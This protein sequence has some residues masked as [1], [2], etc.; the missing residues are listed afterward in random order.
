MTA[1]GLQ[2]VSVASQALAVLALQRLQSAQARGGLCKATR[3]SEASAE[4]PGAHE[5]LQSAQALASL[6]RTLRRS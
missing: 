1:F 4:R 5:L 3:R 2:V 6:Y